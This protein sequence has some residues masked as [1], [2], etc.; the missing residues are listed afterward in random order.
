MTTTTASISPTRAVPAVPA[1][2]AFW[3]LFRKE[4]MIYRRDPL[5][6]IMIFAVPVILTIFLAPALG[7]AY[8]LG[9][10]P[11]AYVATAPG[12]ASPALGAPKAVVSLAEARREVSAGDV[13][14]AVVARPGGRSYVIADPTLPTL[15]PVFLD[16][17]AGRGV[18]VVAPSG[19]TYTD[20]SSQYQQSLFGFALL[21]VFFGAA[22]AAQ[23][24]HRERNWGTWNRVLSLGLGKTTILAATLLPM[25]VIAMI[26]QLLLIG[27]GCLIAGIPIH[28]P[29]FLVLEAAAVGLV[30]AAAACMLAA[31]SAN[32][33]QVP[34]FNNLLTLL[35]GAVAGAL[36]PVALMPGWVQAVAPIFPQYW[37]LD[38]VKGSTSRSAPDT[39]LLLD[40]AVLGAFAVLFATIGR[41]G[42]RWERLRHE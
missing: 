11:P 20:E 8:A 6:L 19:L 36:V 2:V 27:G 18:K 21:N 28:K 39:T 10:N 13:P 3:A 16:R 14:F 9:G 17:L 31:I 5:L 30:V 1:R 33:M 29:G 7:G 22:H 32:D 26:Q 42:M 40:L 25:A 15:L 4:V 35:G 23:A 38:M 37:G 24:L 12:P 41:L 34:Q